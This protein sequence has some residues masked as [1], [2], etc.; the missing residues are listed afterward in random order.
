M[1]TPLQMCLADDMLSLDA[2]KDDIRQAV[3]APLVDGREPADPLEAL[4]AEY[5][6]LLRRAAGTGRPFES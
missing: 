1:I 3:G 2:L 6:Q 5:A 4:E